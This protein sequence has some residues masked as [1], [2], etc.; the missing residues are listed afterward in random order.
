MQKLDELGWLDISAARFRHDAIRS[1]LHATRRSRPASKGG[2]AGVG[3]RECAS[4]LARSVAPFPRSAGR[5]ALSQNF[6]GRPLDQRGPPSGEQHRRPPPRLRGP[7]AR[8]LSIYAASLSARSASST[9]SVKLS[10]SWIG[11]WSRFLEL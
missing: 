8:C 6:G 5:L 2:V 3:D 4:I 11:S 7:D 10:T 9:S 1:K